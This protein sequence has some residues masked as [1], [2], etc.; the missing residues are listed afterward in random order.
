M[1]QMVEAPEKSTVGVILDRELRARLEHAARAHERSLGGE[2][3]ALLREHLEGHPQHEKEGA[4]G[5]VSR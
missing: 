4:R 1:S 5:S 2:V 3:R